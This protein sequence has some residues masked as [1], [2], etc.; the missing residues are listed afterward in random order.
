[1]Q[2]STEPFVIP[3][4]RL[5]PGFAQRVDDPPDPPAEPRPA[6]TAVVLRDAPAG[7]EALLLQRHHAS[8]FVPG[9]YVFPGGRVDE[10][11]AQPPLAEAVRRALGPEPPEPPAAYWAAAVREIF[12][13][14]GVLL[15]ADA[16]GRPAPDAASEPTLAEW[17]ERLMNGRAGLAQVLEAE[18]LD[19]A[20]YDVVY[21]AHWIT[22]VAEP[23]RYDTRFF[24]ARWPE[25]RACVA[26]EREMTDALWL[27]PAAAL[28]RFHE[29]SLPMV[30]PTV[31][32]LE[33]LEPF[34][35]VDEALAAVRGRAVEPVLP[36]LVRTREGV[37]IVVD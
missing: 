35:T 2:G 22:P 9:A 32:T 31:R 11:D 16:K 7:M 37:G 29:G 36:R 28:A 27:T 30:F 33:A 24:L 20:L 8:G 4:D 17:R 34:G 5:P 23:R 25:H 10:E 13:E 15:A 21:Y 26:D 3:A 19:P 18:R 12:E 1:M 6:A 14:T